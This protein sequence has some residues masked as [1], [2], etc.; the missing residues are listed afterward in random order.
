MTSNEWKRLTK[1]SATPGAGLDSSVRS[2]GAVIMINT[3]AG[4]YLLRGN[5]AKSRKALAGRVGEFWGRQRPCLVFGLLSAAGPWRWVV[6]GCGWMRLVNIE[7][8]VG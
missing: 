5:C 8:L 4:G 2:P 1:H 6:G 7:L 3:R